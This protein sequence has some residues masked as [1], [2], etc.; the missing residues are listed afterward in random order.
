MSSAHLS[1]MDDMEKF[2]AN[3]VDADGHAPATLTLTCPYCGRGEI[4][5]DLEYSGGYSEH[6]DWTG[7]TCHHCMAEWNIDGTPRKGP[8]HATITYEARCRMQAVAAANADTAP[9]A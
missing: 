4:E 9:K 8:H 7:T 2:F 5:P 3:G 6:R 1:Y